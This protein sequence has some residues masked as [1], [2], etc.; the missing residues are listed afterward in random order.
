M[1][2]KKRLGPVDWMQYLPSPVIGVDEV[3]RGCL[4]GPVVA[5]AVVLSGYI[6]RKTFFDSK[7]LTETRRQE[8]S[9]LVQFE[10]AWCLGFA[11]VEEIDRLNIFHASLLAMRRAVNGLKLA[12]GHILVDGKFVIPKLPGFQQTA[13]VKG[14]SRAQPISA[15]SIVAKVARDRWMKGLAERIPGYGFEIHKGYGTARHRSALAK[16]GP[17]E[18]HRRSFAGIGETFASHGVASRRISLPKRLDQAL[19]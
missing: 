2:K 15:A 11:S 14:D 9:L 10:H 12:G 18:F 1:P 7:T 17:C 4:A 6:K 5:A 13:L 8:L 3:G 19:S 16:L